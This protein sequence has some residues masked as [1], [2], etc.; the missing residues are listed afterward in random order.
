MIPT[1]NSSSSPDRRLLRPIGVSVA[2]FER[3]RRRRKRAR[4]AAFV[5]RHARPILRL[6]RRGRIR[7]L[8]D[9]APELLLR[10]GEASRLE[11]EMTEAELEL[12]DEIVGREEALDAV[13]RLAAGGGRRP[14]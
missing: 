11:V 6:G 1:R 12:R 14:R 7:Q 3:G 4:I 2:L 9:D 5:L 10:V 13:A 8:V